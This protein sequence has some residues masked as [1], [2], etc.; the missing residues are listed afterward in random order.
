MKR[1]AFFSILV[2]GAVLAACS[3]DGTQGELNKNQPP[4]VW[5]SA[6]PP[7]GS[8]GKYRVQL[9]WGGW[10]PDGE[11]AGYEYIVTDNEGT[12][13]PADTVGVP[14]SPVS[15]NDST[16]TFSADQPVD[17][18]NTT[19]PI[20]EFTR[21]HTFFIRAIDREGLRS[22]EPAYRS[23]TSRTLSPEITIR[24]PVKN[25]LNPALVPPVSTFRWKGTDY[26]DDL[27]ITQEPDSVQWALVNT[28]SP[29][30]PGG[31]TSK[32]L[33][34][35]AY[36]RTEAAAREWYPWVW[37]GA[38]QDSGKFWTTPPV[39]I[40]TYVFAVRAKDEA[41]AITPVLTEGPTTCPTCG[42]LRRVKV[43]ARTSG[44]T[45]SVSND[46]LGVVRTTSCATPVVI[47]DSPAGVP[48]EFKITAD[49]SSYGG[50]VAGYRYGWDVSDLNDPE[51]WEIDVTPF[52]GSIATVPAR[53]FFF[54]THT[55]TMEV[56]DNNGY[57]TR[58]FVKVNVVQ[59][60]LERNLLVVD[61]DVTDEGTTSGW[62]NGGTYPNDAEH[63]AFWLDMLSEVAGFD[64][65]IDMIDTKR[66]DIAL[67]KLAQYKSVIWNVAGSADQMVESNL[68]QLLYQFIKYR[69]KN[70]S[71]G[72]SAG[73]AKANVLALGMAAGSHVMIAGQHPVQFVVN[74]AILQPTA[75]IRYPLILLYDLEGIAV[76]P[77][78]ETTPM[79]GDLS[80]GYRELC[81][82][83]LDYAYQP[84]KRL[85]SRAGGRILYCSVQFIRG[86]DD[87]RND[88]MRGCF[89]LDPDFPSLTLRPE[90]SAPGQFYAESARGLDAEVYNPL[91]FRRGSGMSGSCVY[92][93]SVT[94]PCFQPIYGVECLDTEE[95]TYRQPTAFF[96][97]AYADRVAD[98]P[99]AVGA[100]SVVFG[101][102]PVFIAEAEFRPVMDRILFDEWKLPR[103]TN[104]A[105]RA[106]PN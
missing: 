75:A 9:F 102:P 30:V 76:S 77:P 55:L 44:P 95:E 56:V 26:V 59:F 53:A 52:V 12:F 45:M 69:P 4:T 49:A 99:G 1:M 66:G 6:A 48:L 86:T 84:V 81:L 14:W 104:A 94:R 3:T 32:Y 17:T 20:A 24:V 105:V 7:E 88:G 98:V 100:R 74:R 87:Q 71:E 63:D 50:A 51:Q 31:G 11:I 96:T 34:T 2:L 42:N 18:L 92:V 57:C 19:N 80:F 35:M 93:P 8:T 22:T 62:N 58:V 36:L 16:F 82:E 64:P 54:G 85:R 15:G 28:A 25:A 43:A 33:E 13:N 61:D 47:L 70:P 10:D 37:Y 103:G 73:K 21:S 60:T 65:E 40:G 23:F 83:T 72:L 78:S 29:N 89:S 97:S 106:R 101:F 46:Y 91:Y 39:D 41:G 38:P 79:L 27:L 68:P 5:L 67:T 90:A